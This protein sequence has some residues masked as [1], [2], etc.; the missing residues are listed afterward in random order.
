MS[1][2][3]VNDPKIEVLGE[4]HGAAGP[5]AIVALLGQAHLQQQGGHVERTYRTLAADAFCTRAEAR[6]IIATAAEV[7]LIEIEDEDE[8]RFAARFPAWKRW[9]D[10]FRKARSRENQKA[11]SRGNVTDGHSQSQDVTYQTGPDQT[12]PDQSEAGASE[13]PSA[14]SPAAVPSGQQPTAVEGPTRETAPLSFLL[15]DLIEGNG[16][17][18]PRIGRKWADAERL[19]LSRDGRDPEQAEKLLRW[20]QG[21]EFWRANVLSMPKFREQ[22]DRLLLQAR[23]EHRSRK[24]G[25]GNAEVVDML[26]QVQGAG[27]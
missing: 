5:L 23:A 17:R 2:Q 19:M 10:R 22:Y 9:N 11:R 12:R 26:R 21:H 27:R 3:F 7:A 20:C 13:A 1:T 8:I 18:R 14:V 6:S 4:R 16:A 15:A 24:G 25:G